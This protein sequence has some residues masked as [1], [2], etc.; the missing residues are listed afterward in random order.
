MPL[1]SSFQ[2]PSPLLRSRH[3]L[4]AASEKARK[5]STQAG[6]AFDGPGGETYLLDG[7]NMQHDVIQAYFDYVGRPMPE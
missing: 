5:V 7:G 6:N 1:P 3:S 2:C 4:E